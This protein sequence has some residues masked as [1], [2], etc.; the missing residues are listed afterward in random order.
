MPKST[1]FYNPNKAQ[2]QSPRKNEIRLAQILVTPQQAAP[3]HNLKNDKA[4]NDQQAHNKIQMIEYARCEQGEDFGR[5]RRIIRKI[6]IMR[7]TEGT[8]GLY[9]ESALDKAN[10]ELKK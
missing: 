5:L 4:Q 2:L 1:A 10:P 3:L 9:R 6:Q 8:S 7:R